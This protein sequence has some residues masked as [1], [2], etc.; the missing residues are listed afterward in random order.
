MDARICCCGSGMVCLDVESRSEYIRLPYI[1][2][3]PKCQAYL[4]FSLCKTKF[5]EHLE[6]ALLAA[7]FSPIIRSPCSCDV[8]DCLIDQTSAKCEIFK[9]GG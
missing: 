7:I 8:F 2:F 5:Y 1:P 4:P 3:L 6:G 9:E